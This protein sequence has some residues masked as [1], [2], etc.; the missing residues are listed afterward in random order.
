MAL[1]R[2]TDQAPLEV[3]VSKLLSP[4][5]KK[6]KQKDAETLHA[7][8]TANAGG[9]SS[10]D[11]GLTAKGLAAEGTTAPPKKPSQ[12][13]IDAGVAVS[14]K[15]YMK[16]VIPYVQTQL[17]AFLKQKDSRFGGTLAEV[18]P[19]Q[20]SE[21]AQK[22]FKNFREPWQMCSC[23]SALTSTQL[24]EASGNVF[25]LDVLG[26]K[27]G[28]HDLADAEVTWHRLFDA[29]AIW[30]EEAY[31]ASCEDAHY[32]RFIFQAICLLPLRTLHISMPW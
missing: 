6:S 3:D 22:A 27:F 18:P 17:T 5:A 19:F 21:D 11:A 8:L 28:E 14:V 23:L 20:I 29:G 32:R 1:K 2:K 25:W 13:D 26:T 24:Y 15:E 16:A 10:G 9:A 12:S 4:T 7:G 31:Q 30:S